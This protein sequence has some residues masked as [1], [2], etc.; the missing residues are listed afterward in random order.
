MRTSGSVVLLQRRLPRPA[1]HAQGIGSPARRRAGPDEGCRS[2]I[3]PRPIPRLTWMSRTGP[4]S[5]G[6][7][8]C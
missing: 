3:R 5:V 1:V 2:G 6:W 7:S 8:G 4:D